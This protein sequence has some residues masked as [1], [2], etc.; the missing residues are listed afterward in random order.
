MLAVSPKSASGSSPTVGACGGI[1]SAV[2]SHLGSSALGGGWTTLASL[3]QQKAF[4]KSFNLQR[5]VH[6][7]GQKDPVANKKWDWFSKNWNIGEG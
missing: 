7:K 4:F 1:T 2:C 5:N 6:C 3:S